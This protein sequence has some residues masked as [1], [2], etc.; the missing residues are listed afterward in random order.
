MPGCVYNGVLSHFV[1]LHQNIEKALVLFLARRI[2]II[3]QRTTKPN[4]GDDILLSVITDGRHSAI[5]TRFVVPSFEDDPREG[6][7]PHN[8]LNAMSGNIH[9]IWLGSADLTYRRLDGTLHPLRGGAQMVFSDLGTEAADGNRGFSAYPW[10]RDE[11]ITPRPS[12]RLYLDSRGALR[13]HL[14]N[15]ARATHQQQPDGPGS[16]NL[17]VH[18]YWS[19]GASTR[20][21][22]SAT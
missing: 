14:P 15:G 7:D 1:P 16:S 9:R 2:K 6:D 19:C 10:V 12:R 18:Q 11:L 20:R 8:K 22:R 13:G 21:V 17:A 5:Y 3:E 4:K